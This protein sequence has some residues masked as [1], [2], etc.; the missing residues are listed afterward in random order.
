MPAQYYKSNNIY[1]WSENF[2]NRGKIMKTDKITF[3][4]EVQLENKRRP[5]PAPNAY[6]FKEYVGKEGPIKSGKGT[7]PLDAKRC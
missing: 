4:A 6:S 3:T 1:D 2:K 5:K 7:V